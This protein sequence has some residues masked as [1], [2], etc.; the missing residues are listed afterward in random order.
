MIAFGFILGVL[1]TYYGAIHMAKKSE[2]FKT[3][4]RSLID[5]IK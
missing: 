3:Y 5:E 2:A 4:L 1:T